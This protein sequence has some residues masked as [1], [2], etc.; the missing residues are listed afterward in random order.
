MRDI[1]KTLKIKEVHMFM[2]ST[3]NTISLGKNLQ[4]KEKYFIGEECIDREV[5]LDGIYLDTPTCVIPQ[6]YK[7][8]EVS[9]AKL[10]IYYRIFKIRKNN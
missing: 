3:Y 6:V 7:E 8:D 5:D 4:Y 9:L 10:S 1:K 2:I